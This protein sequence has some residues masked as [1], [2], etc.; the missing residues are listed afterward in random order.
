MTFGDKLRTLR[1]EKN[2]SQEKLADLL[3]TSKQVI[4]RYENNQ[5]TP[6]ITV[7]DEYAKKMNV[8]INYLLDN[9]IENLDKQK[10]QTLLQTT[11]IPALTAHERKVM[12]AYRDQPTMQPAVDRLL[13]ITENGEE[14]VRVFRA[15]R[16]SDNTPPGW[17]DMPAARLQKLR[18][19]PE[20]DDD[21]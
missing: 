16:S 19:A 7:V 5:R 14:T 12:S 13:G 11:A 2:M 3:G 15:A 21:L 10:E 20:S 6:K 18:D 17:V 8:D 1:V 4:S 9:G